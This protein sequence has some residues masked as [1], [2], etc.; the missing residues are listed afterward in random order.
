MPGEHGNKQPSLQEQETPLG[1]LRLDDAVALALSDNLGLASLQARARALAEV[2]SQVGTLPDPTLSLG[3]F[4]VPTDTYSMNQEAMTQT[5]VGIGVTLPFPGKLG[6]REKVADLEAG[7]AEHE[8]AER[9]LAL[10]SSVHSTWWNAIE[11]CCA[12]L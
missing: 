9:R 7:T 6:L 1:M 12:G 5:L 4:S 2:P 11:P 8:V 10:I 3:L